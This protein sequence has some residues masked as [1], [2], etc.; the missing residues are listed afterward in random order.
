MSWPS[1]N[2]VLALIIIFQGPSGEPISMTLYKDCCVQFFA[3]LEMTTPKL[4]LAGA[5]KG[6]TLGEGQ[7]RRETK[8]M[9]QGVRGGGALQM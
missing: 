6:V 3:L 7:K 5:P 1:E 4:T 9:R 8:C 2:I